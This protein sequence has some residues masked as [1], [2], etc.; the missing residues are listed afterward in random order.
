MSDFT[1]SSPSFFY[2]TLV[3]LS[4]YFLSQPLSFAMFG[5]FPL[6]ATGIL[7]AMTILAGCTNGET[8]K[9]VD[10]QTNYDCPTVRS[11]QTYYAGTCKSESLHRRPWASDISRP[12][13]I[14]TS[15]LQVHRSLEIHRLSTSDQVLPPSTKTLL[16]TTRATYYKSFSA[17]ME[18]PLP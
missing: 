4:Y 1:P 16:K 3:T 5:S 17:T 11:I 15:D 14:A 7:F 6:S 10:G 18:Y 9:S 12:S 8:V 2:P 13:L